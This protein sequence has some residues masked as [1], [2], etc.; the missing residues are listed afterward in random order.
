MAFF[1]AQ[2]YNWSDQRD[3]AYRVAPSDNL[4][5]RTFLLNPNRISELIEGNDTSIA[6]P[7]A[8]FKFFDNYLSNREG[9]SYVKTYMAASTIIT[10]ADTALHSTMVTLPI[11]R[12]N[13]PDKATVDTTLPCSCIAYVDD[14]NQDTE[15]CWIIYYLSG[16]K[17]REVLCNYNI[18][19][20]ERLINHGTLTTAQ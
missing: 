8:W 17:R 10:A 15:H 3:S 20:V 14:Y 18:Y 5:Y 7:T 9:W 1:L 16:F 2:V 6:V 11:H 4:G 13:N 19:E 12:N